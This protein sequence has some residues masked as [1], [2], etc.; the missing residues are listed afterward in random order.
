MVRHLGKGQT[1][2]GTWPALVIAL[3]EPLI[4]PIKPRSVN[5]KS[6]NGIQGADHVHSDED[7][8]GVFVADLDKCPQGLGPI[9]RPLP[10]LCSHLDGRGI[11]EAEVSPHGLHDKEAYVGLHVRCKGIVIPLAISGMEEIPAFH[12]SGQFGTA[13]EER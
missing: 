13:P 8:A 6:L 12:R 9:H 5:G 1:E 11:E 10:I 7:L 2:A 4:L 3:G